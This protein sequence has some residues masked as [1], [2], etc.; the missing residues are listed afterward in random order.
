MGQNINFE[1]GKEVR[2]LLGIGVVEK[3]AIY[4]NPRKR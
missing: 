3:N 4:R 1:K 2:E